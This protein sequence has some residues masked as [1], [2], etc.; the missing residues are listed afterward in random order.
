MK[1]NSIRNQLAGT[2]QEIVPGPV[3]SEIV[4]KTAAGT[5]ASVIT[6]RSALEMQ[7]R[8]GDDV[9]VMIKATEASIQKPA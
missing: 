2:V 7:L 8:A 4:V 6:S 3:V 5:L 1:K 9:L